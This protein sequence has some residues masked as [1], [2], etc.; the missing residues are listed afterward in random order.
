MDCALVFNLSADTFSSLQLQPRVMGLEVQTGEDIAPELP[1]VLYLLLVFLFFVL[2]V[3]SCRR[4]AIVDFYVSL[5]PSLHHH[6]Y[7]HQ[8]HHET[9]QL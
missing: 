1:Q 4:I 2:C 6:C 7:Q 8:H 9:G 5:R 3:N